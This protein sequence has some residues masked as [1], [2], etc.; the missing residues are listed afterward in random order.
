MVYIRRY[1]KKDGLY[2]KTISDEYFASLVLDRGLD[3][4]LKRDNAEYEI[5]FENKGEANYFLNKSL[6]RIRLNTR[7]YLDNLDKLPTFSINRI[8]KGSG[9]VFTLEGEIIQKKQ[10]KQG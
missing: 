8:F 9:T 2:G 5:V 1:Y 3:Y 7:Y 10:E 6:S 4:A